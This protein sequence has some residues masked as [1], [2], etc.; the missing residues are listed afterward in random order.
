MRYIFERRAVA[1]SLIA[2]VVVVIV[3]VLL[4][5]LHSSSPT[6]TTGTTLTPTTQKYIP[7][8]TN[9]PAA[10]KAVSKNEAIFADQDVALTTLEL[11]KGSTVVTQALVN[12]AIA[13][14]PTAKGMTATVVGGKATLKMA[15]T[16]NNQTSYACATFTGTSVK[17]GVT[18]LASCP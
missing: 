13:K 2:L 6:S 17:H 15:V 12:E 14:V 4:F 7:P 16:L 8:V 18:I 9:T 1:A 11:M 5:V 10:A 3:V